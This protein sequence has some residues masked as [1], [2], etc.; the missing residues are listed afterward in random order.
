M[1][2]YHKSV[3]YQHL[4][5]GFH[6]SLGPYKDHIKSI[7]FVFLW[8][9]SVIKLFKRLVLANVHTKHNGYQNHALPGVVI[10]NLGMLIRR[11]SVYFLARKNVILKQIAVA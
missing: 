6:V 10:F 11:I 8:I 7:W 3:E 5:E 2:F 1:C 9:Y 4:H